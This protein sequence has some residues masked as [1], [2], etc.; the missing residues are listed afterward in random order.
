MSA[1]LYVLGWVLS[2]KLLRNNMIFVFV[3][4]LIV[5]YVIP[6]IIAYSNNLH[7]DTIKQFVH[8]AGDSSII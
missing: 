5:N 1:C 7:F 6:V 8:S 3:Y 2:L 4:I